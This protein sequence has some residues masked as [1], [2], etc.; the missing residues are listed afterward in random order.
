MKGEQIKT[1]IILATVFIGVVAYA[2]HPQKWQLATIPL[3]KASIFTV[4]S[5]SDFTVVSSSDSTKSENKRLHQQ[6][7]TTSVRALFIGDSMVENLARQYAAMLPEATD[8]AFAVIWY[9]ST[10]RQW[11]ET[12]TLD[13]YIRKHK[14]TFVFVCL[15]SNELFV[16]NA[17]QRKPYIEKIKSKIGSMPYIWIGPPDWKGD[18]GIND[19]IK[20]TVGDGCFYDSRQLTLERGSDNIHPTDKGAAVWADSIA[21]WMAKQN[22]GCN[23]NSGRKADN[24][25]RFTL[26]QPNFKGIRTQ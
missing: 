22:I 16:N 20:Q 23:V 26:L 10:T 7:D 5:A 24:K 17:L 21:S 2:L 6:P 19:A 4:V 9:G 13:Y 3:Q 12:A 25:C 1:F 11:A 8:S 14:P 18:T 15:G